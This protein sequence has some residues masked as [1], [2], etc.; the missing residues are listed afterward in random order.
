MKKGLICLLAVFCMLFGTN[1][2]FARIAGHVFDDAELYTVQEEETL[3]QRAEEIGETYGLDVLFLTTEDTQGLSAREYA[4]QFFL[5]GDFG[6]GAEQDGIVFIIDMQERDAQMVTSGEAIS[7]FTDAYLAQIWEEVQPYLSDGAYAEAM[8]VF[9]D[10]VIAY[11]QAYQEY[12][13]N[14]EEYVS[15]YQQ[16][17]QQKQLMVFGVVVV[18]LSLVCAGTGVLLMRRAHRN[19]RPFTDGRAYLKENG[20][21]LDIDRDAFVSTHTIRTPL[22]K[23]EDPPSFGGGSSTFQSGGHTFGGGGGKF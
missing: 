19:V 11:C 9:L 14:P 20:M 6:Y 7:I 17:Q 1:P 2:V 10:Q 15:V 22:P 5:D 8:S 13:E 4:A 23:N 21:R 12:L 16:E 18:L 3:T